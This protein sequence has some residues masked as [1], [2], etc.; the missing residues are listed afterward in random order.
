MAVLS[1]SDALSKTAEYA[2]KSLGFSAAQV[3]KDMQIDAQ[4]TIFSAWR[5]DTVVITEKFPPSIYKE[6]IILAVAL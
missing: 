2:L 3:A 5:N 1:R 6:G 4:G